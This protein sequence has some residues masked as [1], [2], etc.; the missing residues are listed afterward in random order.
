MDSA[1][2]NGGLTHVRYCHTSRPRDLLVVCPACGAPALANKPSESDLGVLIA[3]LSPGWRLD[4]W[5]V[6]CSKCP[7]RVSGLAYSSLPPLYLT[8]VEFN[9]WAWNPQHLDCLV[10]HLEGRSTKDDPYDWFMTYIPSKWK[11]DRKRTLKALKRCRE[12]L[13]KRDS[14]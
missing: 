4:D 8:S 2:S 12:S 11:S 1:I 10:D 6:A 7:K 13:L 5:E 3:D 9:V 14:V